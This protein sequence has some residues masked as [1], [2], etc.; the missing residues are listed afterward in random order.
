MT[1]LTTR[2]LEGKR[3]VPRIASS[4]LLRAG[5]SYELWYAAGVDARDGD[6]QETFPLVEGE[7][8]VTL[9]LEPVPAPPIPVLALCGVLGLAFARWRDEVG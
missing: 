7:G 5:E 1:T 6:D 2:E 3:S 9:R 4:G 8:N